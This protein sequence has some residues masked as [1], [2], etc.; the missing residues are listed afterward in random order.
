[1]G[2][3]GGGEREEM[4]TMFA[5]D[6]ADFFRSVA[7]EEALVLIRRVEDQARMEIE[8]KQDRV[9]TLW[10]ATEK[11]EKLQPRCPDAP[12]SVLETALDCVYPRNGA[13]GQGGYSRGFLDSSGE[14]LNDIGII[15]AYGAEP[16]VP[17]ANRS[18]WRP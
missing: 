12:I 3:G 11:I 5:A 8:R 10:L 17:A 14:Q 1:V 2:G 9:N 13:G 6:D 16:L 15:D 18:Q 7:R 4:M